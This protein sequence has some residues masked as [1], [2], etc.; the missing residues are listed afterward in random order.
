M[1]PPDLG[2]GGSG[3]FQARAVIVV[4]MT[5]SRVTLAPPVDTSPATPADDTPTDADRNVTLPVRRRRLTVPLVLLAL[6]LLTPGVWILLVSQSTDVGTPLGAAAD[7]PG[8]V[9]RINGVIPLESDGWLP[10][11]PQDALDGPADA[12]MHR[13]RII[14]EVTALSPAGIRFSAADY[15]ID[16]LGAGRPRL[17]WANPEHQ[18]VE[19]GESLSATLVF[20]IPNENVA[21][22]LTGEDD[23]R[24]ALGVGH[25]TAKN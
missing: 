23:V 9:A 21:L 20:E 7:L 2:V 14:V 8:G 4:T 13:V 19:Q 12:G 25:H 16:G 5:R 1:G 18:T 24:L 17:L 3:F 22:S 15:A 11:E 6:I 10:P